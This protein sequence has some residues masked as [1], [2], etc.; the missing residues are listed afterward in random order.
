MTL[1]TSL[2]Y[3][4][5]N[6]D[7]A[8]CQASCNDEAAFLSTICKVNHMR[9]LYV[10]MDNRM[11]NRPMSRPCFY[12]L[13]CLTFDNRPHMITDQ[14]R[15]CKP[16]ITNAKNLCNEACTASPQRKRALHFFENIRKQLTAE[17][18]DS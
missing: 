2:S 5:P 13:H 12:H 14:R 18:A 10:C 1:M 8:K 15:K 4:R 9:I 7:P 17:E 11:D 16:L 3:I 6:L